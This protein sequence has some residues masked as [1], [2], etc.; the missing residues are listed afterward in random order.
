MKRH[1]AL[2]IDRGRC[3]RDILHGCLQSGGIDV[4]AV[5]TSDEAIE[6]LATEEIDVVMLDSSESGADRGSVLDY[7]N[8][9]DPAMLRRVILVADLL[10]APADPRLFGIVVKPYRLETVV[11]LVHSCITSASDDW[12]GEPSPNRWH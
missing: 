2:V 11:S 12:A 6:K 3:E 5:D 1:R 4:I 10:E 9:F 8:S 7:L